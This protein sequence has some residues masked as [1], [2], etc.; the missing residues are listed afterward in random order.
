MPVLYIIRGVPG[1]GKSTLA[2]DMSSGDISGGDKAVVCEADMF[3]VNSLA[4]Y[5]FDPARLQEC[6]RLCQQFVNTH[7]IEGTDHIYV[8]NTFIRKWEADVYYTL[9]KMWQYEVKVICCEGEYKNVHG[10]PE[11]RVDLMR[12]NMEPYENQTFYRGN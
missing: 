12:A 9:A 10:V 4:E 1:S 8:S 3:M 11:N 2:R 5:E 7:M 6:H